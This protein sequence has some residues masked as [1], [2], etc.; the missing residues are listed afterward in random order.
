MS[1]ARPP[2]RISF[3]FTVEER[4]RLEIVA[5]GPGDWGRL[6]LWITSNAGRR[7]LLVAMLR[8]LREAREGQR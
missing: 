1:E 6:A 5:D 4:P 3:T 8:L 2:A 7:K